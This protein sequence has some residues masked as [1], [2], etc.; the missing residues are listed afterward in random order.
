MNFTDSRST[1]ER[2][3]DT[4]MEFLDDIANAAIDQSAIT[5]EE[6]ADIFVK[7]LEIWRDYYKERFEFYEQFIDALRKRIP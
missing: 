5:A 6:G 4:A 3:S 2:L 7:Q 1:T